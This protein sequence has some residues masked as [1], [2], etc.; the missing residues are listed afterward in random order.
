MESAKEELEAALSE[1]FVE[2]HAKG[3]EEAREVVKRKAT[4]LAT[5]IADNIK[6][7]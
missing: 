2:L 7:G 5:T 4:A 1:V 6:G 3:P